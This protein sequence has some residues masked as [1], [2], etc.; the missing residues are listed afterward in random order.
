MTKTV[1]RESETY[2]TCTLEVSGYGDRIWINSSICRR[3]I[4][5]IDIKSGKV[6]GLGGNKS[7]AAFIL[8]AMGLS[9]AD[10][11]REVLA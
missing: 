3:G 11:I 1:T 2:R 6:V 5:Y 7:Q 8:Q 10:A 4:G 9:P